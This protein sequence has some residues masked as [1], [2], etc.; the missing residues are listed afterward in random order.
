MVSFVCDNPFWGDRL[1]NLNV[2]A[3]VP[4]RSVSTANLTPLVK[5][6]LTDRSVHE[7]CKSMQ[8]KMLAEEDGTEVFVRELYKRLPEG[9][10]DWEKLYV[11]APLASQFTKNNILLALLSL[12]MVCFA[13]F[14]SS[15]R[16][17]LF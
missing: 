11:H 16:S 6:L 14:V 4:S 9:P 13:A 15:R 1:T 3:H 10:I 2:G 12:C 7:A 8:K 5:R 17:S